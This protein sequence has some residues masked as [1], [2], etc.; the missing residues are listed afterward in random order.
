MYAPQQSN[1]VRLPIPSIHRVASRF[2]GGIPGQPEPDTPDEPVLP[3]Q[4]SEPGEPIV[5]DQAPPV[6]LVRG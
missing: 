6:P 5:P 2:M 3:D 4:P 1:Q